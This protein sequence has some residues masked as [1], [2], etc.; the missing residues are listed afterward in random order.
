MAWLTS[1]AGA[2]ER[3]TVMLGWT[4]EAIERKRRQAENLLAHRKER[5]EAFD[6]DYLAIGRVVKAT[7]RLAGAPTALALLLEGGALRDP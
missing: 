5:V 4:L 7:L 3:Q 6:S 2:L 1:R